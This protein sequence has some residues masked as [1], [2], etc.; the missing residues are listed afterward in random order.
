MLVDGQ[1]LIVRSKPPP[2][3]SPE[4]GA[5]PAAAAKA[6]GGLNLNQ[7]SAADLDQLPGIGPTLAQRIVE[8]RQ[9]LGPFQSVEQLLEE[10]LVP[11]PTYE[12]IKDLLEG[13]FTIDGSSGT[14]ASTRQRGSWSFRQ[15]W[16]FTPSASSAIRLSR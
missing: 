13:L 2:R 14:P 3:P 16:T 7:A 15:T 5:P 6:D 9:R 1:Q 11:A 4:A 10:K 8:R 12:R